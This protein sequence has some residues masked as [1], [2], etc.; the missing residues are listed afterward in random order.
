MTPVCTNPLIVHSV[1]APNEHGSERRRVDTFECPDPGCS[2]LAAD[3]LNR[4]P[5][6]WSWRLAHG[7]VGAGKAFPQRR[8]AACHHIARSGKAQSAVGEI[9]SE[10]FLSNG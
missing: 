1:W 3:H 2:A 9:Q 4:L 8:C 6:A 10:S 7:R 5:C